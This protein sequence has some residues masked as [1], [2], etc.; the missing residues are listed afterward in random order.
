[1]FSRP[2]QEAVEGFPAFLRPDWPAPSK[3]QAAVSLRGG[4]VSNGPYAS[5]NLGD[6]VGD[7]PAA[8]AENRRRLRG[9]LQLP[10]DPHWLRQVHGKRVVRAAAEE[11]PEADAVWTSEAETVCAI[12]T[13]DCLPVLFCDD[14]GQHLA[15]A[16][17]GWR[18]LCAG[19]LEATVAALPV[20]P[21][22]LMA[23]L[24]PAIGPQAFEVG[25]EVREAFVAHAAAAAEAFVAQAGGKYRADLPQLARQR[26]AAVG[27]T[28][29]YGGRE[30]TVQG[31]PHYFSHRRDGR[32]GRMA[33]L[34]WRCT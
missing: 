9:A 32:S 15:A 26:L 22:R 10:A 29:I 25:P 2:N 23:W 17:A 33:T 8:V 4:G 5:L 30:C 21:A 14:S 11:R 18:G 20:A 7:E 19:V 28:R 3:V 31:A 6:H 13:A 34:I 12:L 27:I 16:H 1:M 24:G